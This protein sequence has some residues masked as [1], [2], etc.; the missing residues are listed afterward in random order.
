MNQK[1]I[2]TAIA[3][4]LLLQGIAFFVMG[5]QI[6][7]S[8]F[9][10]LDETGKYAGVTLMQVISAISIIVALIAAWR[11]FLANPFLP[12]RFHTRTRHRANP[13]SSYTGSI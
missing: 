1:N 3:V 6:I 7:A 2:F 4:V 10:N 12:A 11:C 13:H 8:S 9:P 5:D